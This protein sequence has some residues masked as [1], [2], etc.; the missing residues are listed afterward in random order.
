LT[1]TRSITPADNL[2]GQKV[3]VF[4]IAHGLTQAELAQAIG[5]TFQQVQKYENGANRIGSARL[6]RIA[7]TLGVPVARFFEDSETLAA[8][9]VAGPVGTDLLAGL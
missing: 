1:T 6:A 4:R 8:A 7:D 5:V 9:N 3:R 2:V